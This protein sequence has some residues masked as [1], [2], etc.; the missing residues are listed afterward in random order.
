MAGKQRDAK[1][2][3]QIRE[4]FRGVYEDHVDLF[5]YGT[6]MSDQH[7]RLLLNRKVDNAFLLIDVI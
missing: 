5:V 6:M 1:E 3:A 7:V 2:A 4:D